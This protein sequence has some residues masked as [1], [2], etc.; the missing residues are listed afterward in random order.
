[1][2]EARRH[3]ES[4]RVR[5]AAQAAELAEELA[6]VVSASEGVALDDEHDPDGSTVGFERARVAALLERARS[7]LAAFDEALARLDAGTYG[8]CSSCGVP[9]PAERLAVLPDAV[10]CTSCAARRS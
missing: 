1:M 9:I 5:V 4:E 10:S 7:R 2:E 8:V 6:A 3:L